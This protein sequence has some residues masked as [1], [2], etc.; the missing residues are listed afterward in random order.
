MSRPTWDATHL[1]LAGVWARRA[2]CLRGQYGCV[3]VDADNQVLASGYNGAPRGLP[4]CTDPLGPMQDVRT[5]EDG[6]VIG[7]TPD[8]GCLMEDSHCVRSVHAE[9]NGII[10]AAR[11]GVSLL[12]SRLYVTGRPCQRCALA[13]VQVGVVE[14]IWPKEQTYHT[15]SEGAVLATFREAGI[16]VRLIQAGRESGDE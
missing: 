9:L 8:V 14:V 1:T 6:S 10:Q 7:W 15:D 16:A 13:I 3:Y 12:G 2:T 4:H 5:L 11:T